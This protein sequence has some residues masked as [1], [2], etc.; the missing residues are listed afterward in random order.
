M[1]RMHE[2]LGGRRVHTMCESESEGN[3]CVDECVKVQT[4]GHQCANMY[5]FVSVYGGSVDV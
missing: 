5:R 4:C 2:Y 3:V 1:N